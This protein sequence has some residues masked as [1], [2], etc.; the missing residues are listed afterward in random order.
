L[1]CRI[2][3]AFQVC[4]FGRHVGLLRVRTAPLSTSDTIRM[5]FWIPLP[6]V[7]GVLNQALLKLRLVHEPLRFV[8]FSPFALGIKRGDRR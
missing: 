7:Y 5:I 4:S 1:R 2:F 3:L 8:L 6:G